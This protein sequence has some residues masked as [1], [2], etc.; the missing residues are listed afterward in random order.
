MFP[1]KFNLSFLFYFSFIGFIIIQKT[2]PLIG[3]VNLEEELRILETK[4][5]SAYGAYLEQVETKKQLEADNVQMDEEKKALMKQLEAEQGNLSEYTER[6]AKASAARAD[7]EIQLKDSGAKLVEKE[8]ARQEITQEKR[9]LEQ[10]NGAI[11]KDI[12]DLELAI[13]KL[14]QEKTNRDH[15]MRTLNDEIANQDEVINKL[16]KQK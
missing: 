2:R 1:I 15:T 4:A 9:V 16:N 7:I 10:D 5:N 12:E 3:Q 11:K 8:Q 13:Q 14:E 6:Q